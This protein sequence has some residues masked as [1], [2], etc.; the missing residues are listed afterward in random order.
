MINLRAEIGRRIRRARDKAGI[1]QEE[2]AAAV[3]L[4]RT[5]IA[6]LEAGRQGL[7]L[8]DAAAMARKLGTSVDELAGLPARIR[9]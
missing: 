1:T 8:E 6:N 5:S 4:S 9:A 7:C 2:L 3:G